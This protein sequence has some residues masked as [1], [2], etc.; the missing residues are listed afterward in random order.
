MSVSKDEVKYIAQLARLY[1]DDEQLEKMRK[2]MDN[3][4]SF[5]DTLSALDTKDLEAMSHVQDNEN[6][7]DEDK[8]HDGH[9]LED[10]LKNAPESVDNYFA[11][12]KVVE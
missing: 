2:D 5:A 1:F 3:L 6:V 11:V 8:P 9:K 12:P 4:V 7:F 10:L